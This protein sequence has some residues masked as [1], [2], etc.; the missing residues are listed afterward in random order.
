MSRQVGIEAN[1]RGW[2][3]IK[4][5]IEDNG[6]GVARERLASGSHL[7]QDCSEGKQVGAC[8][9]LFAARLL[10]RHVCHRSH[11]A[12]GAGEVGVH[13][14][15]HRTARRFELR[16]RSRGN[17]GQSKVEDLGLS[18]LGQKQVRRFQIA[19]H[20]ARRMRHIKRISNLSGKVHEL[21]NRKGFSLDAV[22]QR[23]AFKALHHD[24]EPILVFANVVDGADVGVIESRCGPGLT[25]KSFSRLRIL[26]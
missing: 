13:G 15:G 26:R 23:R 10:R 11:G 16:H 8:I 19:M 4:D 9:Q 17:F 6:G 18:T 1:R 3:L 14:G 5:G 24:V 2:R 7:V 20:N 12:A 22:L 21:F 25:L